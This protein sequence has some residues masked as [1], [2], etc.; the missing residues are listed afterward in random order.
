MLKGVQ[1]WINIPS[2]KHSLQK[3]SDGSDDD[4]ED[5]DLIVVWETAVEPLTDLQRLIFLTFTIVVAIFAICGNILVLY[6]NFSR[7]VCEFF[8]KI[9]YEE[10]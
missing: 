3:T 10:W 5:S 9:Y 8:V 7:F 1:H 2:G 6:V 4:E